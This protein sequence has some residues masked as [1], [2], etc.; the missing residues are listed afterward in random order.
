MAL[1]AGE[2][3]G[4]C[5]TP[6]VLSVDCELRDEVENGDWL[7]EHLSSLPLLVL[8]VEEENV[9]LLVFLEHRPSSSSQAT[10]Q[11]AASFSLPLVSVRP[12]FV[13]GRT[14]S[15]PLPSSSVSPPLDEFLPP[16]F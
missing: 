3:T 2:A 12:P 9:L 13:V 1:G 8:Q 16:F 14:F 7:Q 4:G 5:W 15:S 10:S 11:P 6:E